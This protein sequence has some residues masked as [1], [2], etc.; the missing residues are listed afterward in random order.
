MTFNFS[1]LK[2]LDMETLKKKSRSRPDIETQKKKSLGIG[3]H[4]DLKK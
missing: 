3:H 4:W 2:S 1:L